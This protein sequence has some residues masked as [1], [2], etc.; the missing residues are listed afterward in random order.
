M[1]T[2]R[3]TTPSCPGT[4][5]RAIPASRRT[6]DT[7]ETDILDGVDELAYCSPRRRNAYVS[8]RGRR[9]GFPQARA[10]RDATGLEV[11]SAVLADMVWAAEKPERIV[12]ADEMTSPA[13]WKCSGP[14]WPGSSHFTT[15]TPLNGRCGCSRR[16]WILTIRGSQ[17]CPVHSPARM[18]TSCLAALIIA[19]LFWGTA[20]SVT[21]TPS[22]A[23][24]RS[25]S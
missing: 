18:I 15:W 8:A 12:E 9:S 6:R 3:P 21:S 24:A 13:A 2:T 16:T 11:T 23:S 20:V 4:A 19:S 5:C 25:H 17:K 10:L 1:P 22:A 14:T 7:D